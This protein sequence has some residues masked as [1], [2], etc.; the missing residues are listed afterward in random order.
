MQPYLI[1]AILRNVARRNLSGRTRAQQASNNKPHDRGNDLL[2]VYKSYLSLSV[3]LVLDN[4]VGTN[5][6]PPAHVLDC[7][8]GALARKERAHA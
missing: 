6:V 7:F 8:L 4:T 1:L 3:N 5:I 2:D